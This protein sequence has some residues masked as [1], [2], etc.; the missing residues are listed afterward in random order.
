MIWFALLI[1]II[2]TVILLLFFKRQV[3]ISELIT[4][5][6][7]SFISVIIIKY[8]VANNGF[9]DTEYLAFKVAKAEY[10]EEWDEYVYETCTST[11]ADGNTTTYDCSYVD[12]HPPSW[13]I[14]TTSGLTIDVTKN[15]YE[16]LCRKFKVTPTFVDMHRYYH[17]T[18]GDMY[19]VKW[20]GSFDTKEPITLEHTYQNKVMYSRNVFNFPE[21]TKEDKEVYD[22]KDY[23]KVDDYAVSWDITNKYPYLLGYNN[24]L[25]NHKL[26]LYNSELG[27]KKQCILF[28]IVFKNKP[29][30]AALYQQ[31]YWKNGNKNEYVLCIGVDGNDK[32]KWAKSFSWTEVHS[33]LIDIDKYVLKKE[34]LD[35]DNII[36]YTYTQLSTRFERKSFKDFDYLSV[37]PP[38]WAII[39]AYI[40]TFIL[41]ALLSWYFIANEIEE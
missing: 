6:A 17:Y 4:F 27:G 10:Y 30:S 16:H 21:V 24:T 25:I 8:I 33:L 35:L 14:I 39:T 15:Y 28:V 38:T 9:R 22:L 11:D 13:R 37:A 3:V 12:E 29:E 40:V 34:T 20:D 19:Y 31:A 23:P 32:I 41:C 5:I 2:F 26:N 1:P 36:D 7:V 18:D